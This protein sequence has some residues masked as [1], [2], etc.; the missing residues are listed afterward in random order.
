ML[1]SELVAELE[2]IK[3]DVGDVRVVSI[4]PYR[5]ACTNDAEVNYDTTK[6]LIGG[7]EP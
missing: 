5:G 6:V 1:I 2:I 7:K 3:Q 4:V